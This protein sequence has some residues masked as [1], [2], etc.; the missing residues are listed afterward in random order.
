M[1]KESRWLDFE[2]TLPC[3]TAS[4]QVKR[5]R[6]RHGWLQ[7]NQENMRSFSPLQLRC[8][9]FVRRGYAVE[10]SLEVPKA[11]VKLR[12]SQKSIKRTGMTGLIHPDDHI[13]RVNLI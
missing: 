8:I 7:H 4:Y 3:G 2:A 6:P 5:H 11:L 12:N 10:A 1:G 9:G 13:Q